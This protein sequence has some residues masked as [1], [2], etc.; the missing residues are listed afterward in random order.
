MRHVAF[1][2]LLLIGSLALSSSASL[3]AAPVTVR[4]KVTDAAGQLLADVSVTLTNEIRGLNYSGKTDEN[5]TYSFSGVVAGEYR[6]KFAKEGYESLQGIVSVVARKENVFDMT[7][8]SLA[9]KPA[10]PSWQEKNLRAHDLYV[11]NKYTEA[12]ALYREILAA[13]PKVAFIHFDAG[14]CAFH[15]KD[16]EAAVKSYR[17]AIRLKPDFS[18]AYTN[19]ANTY[20]HMKKFD[21]AIP[22][23]ESAIR[24]S[25]AAGALFYGLG[26]LYLNS[27]QAARAVPYLEKFATI[28]PKNPSAYYSLGA[29][30][31]ETEDLAR[32]VENYSKFIGLISD[33][34]EIVRVRGIIED[35]KSRIKK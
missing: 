33:E 26:I 21:E 22:F 6:L 13:D 12:L 5:G 32:A 16:Y 19:L 23:F 15:L 24:S 2:A 11:Q 31:A 18:E 8:R 9:V 29:A 7:L 35:L 4:G 10:P 25:A 20:V 17:E 3:A 28:E 27:G 34:Q 1:T 14:N 30:Y